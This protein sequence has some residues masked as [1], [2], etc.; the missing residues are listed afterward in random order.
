MTFIPV[1]DGLLQVFD[2]RHGACA[3]LTMPSPAG[4]RRI[5]IDCGHSGSGGVVFYPG[6]H[7]KALNVSHI[8]ALFAMNYDEDHASGFPD[9]LQ[10]GGSIGCI[11]GNPSVPPG[12]VRKLK[13]EDGMG[14]GIDALTAAL[15][16][17]RQQGHIE[18]W[19]IIPGLEIRTCWNVY[20]GFDDENNLSLA[21]ELRIHGWNFL[22]SGDMEKPGLTNLL[23]KT[24]FFPD[25][26]RRADV[27]MASHHGRANGVCQ[28]MFDNYGCNPA[29]V[30]VSD[31]YKQYDSQ[32]TT[33]YYGSKAKGYIG[34]RGQGPRH[35]LT[36][37][38]DGDINFS[39]RSGN[40]F[41]G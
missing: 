19:P 7:L 33:T 17:R 40:C 24:D 2:V 8:D 13:T 21:L 30:V 22:F 23:A 10:N 12:V 15:T 3:L 16:Q 25:M 20:P 32:E 11:Y 35:V 9:L 4:P 41:A 28:S 29:L 38:S 6:R 37:R 36:T 39:F 26:V 18:T 34:F 27:L 31:D 14:P 1:H 5:L